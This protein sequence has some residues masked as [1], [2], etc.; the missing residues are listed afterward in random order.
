MQLVTE[1]ENVARKSVSIPAQLC[2]EV[3]KVIRGMLDRNELLK[4]NISLRA[5]IEDLQ[6]ELALRPTLPS[7]LIGSGLIGSGLGGITNFI[8]HQAVTIGFDN[9]A[10][11]YRWQDQNGNWHEA[12][13]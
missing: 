7:P 12:K 3:A 13:P 9:G 1:L 6:R 8:P 4:E 11:V 10:G 5:Q 2:G